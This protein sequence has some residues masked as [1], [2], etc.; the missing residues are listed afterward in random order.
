[1]NSFVCAA[2]DNESIWLAR[3]RWK[4]SKIW[5]EWCEVRREKGIKCDK[6]IKWRLMEELLLIISVFMLKLPL[7][8][9][10]CRNNTK[11]NSLSNFFLL[12][13]APKLSL[14]HTINLTTCVPCFIAIYSIFYTHFTT[15]QQTPG[16]Q[17][18]LNN[19]I[20]NQK[21]LS[22]YFTFFVVVTKAF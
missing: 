7:W 8:R 5:K 4:Y 20:N 2:K 9:I 3:L 16:L 10:L 14:F 15:S 6:M 19:K 13:K 22:F 17:F 12:L 21:K 18:C 1:M 11:K